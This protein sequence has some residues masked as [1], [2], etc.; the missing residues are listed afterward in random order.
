MNSII[1]FFASLL[2]NF[3]RNQI[4]EDIELLRTD[5]KENILPAYEAAARDMKSKGFR[6]NVI[7][8]FNDLFIHL[9]PQTRRVGFVEA[10]LDFFAPMDQNLA[11]IQEYVQELFAKDVT[12]DALTYRKVN[13]IRYL[14]TVRFVQRYASRLLLRTLAAE[15]NVAL[16]REGA[17]DSQL[18]PMELRWL[19]ENQNAYFASVKALWHTPAQLRQVLESIPDIVV[20]P[21]RAEIIRS[22]IGADKL[23]PLKFGLISFG[24]DANINP[25]YH[26]RMV[27]AEAQVAEYKRKVEEKRTLELRLLALKE[28]YEGKQDA[29]LAQNIEY[30]EGRLHR[31]NYQIDKLTAEYA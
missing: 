28:A 3:E 11:V 26:F 17:V 25:I 13:I 6:A 21:E 29:K 5:A 8:K 24:L 15:T 12:K 31:L 19:V 18:S 14:E 16:G 30:S 2:P 27:Y 4:L 7:K 23:D 9:F 1:K 10:T 22:T 20:I